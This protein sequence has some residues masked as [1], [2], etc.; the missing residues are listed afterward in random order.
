ME[1][2]YNCD[3]AS[4]KYRCLQ[5]P[6]KE[7]A[8]CVDCKE[9]HNRTKGCSSHTFCEIVKKKNVCNN[10]ET[11]EAKF[12]C[13]DCDES[14]KYLCLG[15]SV[16]HPKIKAFRGH[17]VILHGEQFNSRGGAHDNA[18]TTKVNVSTIDWMSASMVQTVDTVYFDLTSRNFT[19][20]VFWR[21]LIFSIFGSVS[22]YLTSRLIFRKYASLVNIALA[23]GLYQ[24]LQSS[25]FKVS[26]ADKALAKAKP[27]APTPSTFVAMLSA[28]GITKK[29]GPLSWTLDG[30]MNEEDF[31][32][33]FWYSTEAKKASLRPRGRPYKRRVP[34]QQGGSMSPVNKHTDSQ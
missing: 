28:S 3:I 14:S 8:F 18:Q 11:S 15:C 22:Y 31:K 27:G 19:D 1:F 2:C 16:I 29:A 5:C 21:T 7:S 25:R 34:S 17:T 9:I 24:W 20:L 6:T 12:I 23:I 13:K 4:A 33:E 32:D 30:N 10:C 26:E